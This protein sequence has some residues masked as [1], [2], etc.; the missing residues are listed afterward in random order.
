M[1]AELRQSALE[2]VRAAALQAQTDGDLP[3]FLGELERLRVEILI[4]ATSSP[5]PQLE[6]HLLSV[7]EVAQRIGRSRWWVYSNKNS[8]PIVRLPTGGYRFSEK[9]LKRWIE[10]RATS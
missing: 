7:A 2:S 6:D 9:R 3:V 1:T 5:E 10:R 8:L 4:S